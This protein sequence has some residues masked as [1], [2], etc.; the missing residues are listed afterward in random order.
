M[1]W[2]RLELGDPTLLADPFAAFLADFDLQ[3]PQG[4]P[5]R[6]VTRLESGDLHC[7][8]VVYLSPEAADLARERGATPS[9][10]PSGSDDSW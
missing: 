4:T 5:A 9:A 6:C 1:T 7:V 3:H 2:H 8:A 10:A